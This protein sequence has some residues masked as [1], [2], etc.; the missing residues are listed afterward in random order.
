M[1][2]SLSLAL[3]I[4][5]VLLGASLWFVFTARQVA[6]RI[7]PDPDHLSIS[8]PMI[9]AYRPGFGMAVR[10]G[11]KALLAKL[12]QGLAIVKA[13][14]RFDVIYEKWFGEPATSPL[15]A[16]LVRVAAIALAIAAGTILAAV[17][18]TISLRQQVAQR[19]ADLRHE[20]EERQSRERDLRRTNRLLE[21]VIDQAPFG[22][23]VG[24]GRPDDWW[25]TMCNRESERIT[26]TSKDNIRRIHF[27]GGEIADGHLPWK[28]MRL[29]GTPSPLME[30]PL[31]KA[32]QG[33]ETRDAEMVVRREDGSEKTVLCNAAPIYDDDGTIMAGLIVYPDITPMKEREASF[34]ALVEGTNTIAWKMD[35]ESGRFTYVSPHAEDMLGHPPETW[36]DMAFWVDNIHPDDRDYAVGTCSTETAAGRDHDFDYRMLKPDGTPVWLR[37]IVTVDKDAHGKAV[38]LTGFM[39]DINE[40]KRV[41]AELTRSNQL[42]SAIIEQAPFGIMVGEG[43]SDNWHVTL[44]NKEAERINGEPAARQMALGFENGELVGG[45]EL[46]WQIHRLDGSRWPLEKAPLPVAMQGEVTRD[47]E[48]LLRRADGG[49][50]AI[51][52]NGAPVFGED[53]SI[54]AGLVMFPDISQIKKAEESLR[55]TI[56]E[57]VHSNKEL[58]R[59]AFVASHDLQEPL[60]TIVIFS[61]ILDQKLAREGDE[62]TRENLGYVVESA[63]RMR[64]LVRDLLD[65]SRVK[66]S[67]RSFEPV[68]TD[69]V[70]TAVRRTLEDTLAKAGATLEVSSLPNAHGDH[71]MIAQLFL[72]LISNAIKFA[73]P[74]IPAAIRVTGEVEA[75][76]RT[77]CFAVTDNGIGI[78]PEYLKGVFEVFKRLHTAEAYPGTGIGLALC[79]RIVE[80]HGGRIWVES[81]PGEGSVFRFTLP[82]AA[83]TDGSA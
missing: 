6:I 25:I 77:C 26:G 71:A 37:D 36:T 55:R 69:E 42:L 57:L 83:T 38:G 7:D 12:E 23:L 56:D 43:T 70:L 24:E 68:D 79:Q 5:L 19:T 30:R 80:H 52:C 40:R 67:G 29:D 18:W 47:A 50:T 63:K 28:M 35:L 60:R 10:K 2:W 54:I 3:G 34:R 27:V 78:E 8:G 21:A 66:S 49:E 17:L 58:E 20:V 73:R 9:D 62:E 32:M 22:I 74:G 15:D 11:N 45:D 46:T 13:T 76:G 64:A 39:V 16:P 81:E 65:Y 41:E 82:L 59:F 1:K 4:F 14:G 53:G 44:V 51:L 75:D 61:Q 31:P 72:N 33:H 48:M